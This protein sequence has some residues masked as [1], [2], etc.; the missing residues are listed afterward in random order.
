[1]P[2]RFPL[3]TSAPRP[4]SVAESCAQLPFSHAGTNGRMPASRIMSTSESTS[5]L[6]VVNSLSP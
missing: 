4:P 2:R 5:G 3:A 6:P 1:M